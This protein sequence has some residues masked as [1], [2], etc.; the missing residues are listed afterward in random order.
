MAWKHWDKTDIEADA[1]AR[2]IRKHRQM[3]I[4]APHKTSKLKLA[5]FGSYRR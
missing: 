4:K 2:A 1:E 3:T 5:V